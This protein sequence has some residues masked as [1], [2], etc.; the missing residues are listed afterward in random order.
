MIP[1]LSEEKTGVTL[2]VSNQPKSPFKQLF[3]RLIFYIIF[4]YIFLILHVHIID[5]M[6]RILSIRLCIGGKLEK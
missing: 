1:N 5:H 6:H 2:I 4:L 3:K